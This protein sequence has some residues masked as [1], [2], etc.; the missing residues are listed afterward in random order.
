MQQQSESAVTRKLSTKVIR[1]RMEDGHYDSHDSQ[2]I[3]LNHERTMTM[4]RA[5][6]V[7]M[8]AKNMEADQPFSRCRRARANLYLLPAFVVWRESVEGRQ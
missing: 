5:H 7:E 3:G 4:P 1:M 6:V 2:D 8:V